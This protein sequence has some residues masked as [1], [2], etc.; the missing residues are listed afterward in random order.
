M[1]YASKGHIC[2]GAVKDDDIVASVGDGITV[3]D[4][5]FRIIYQ[6]RIMKDMFGDCVGQLCHDAYQQAD[7]VCPGCPVAACLSTGDI[8]TVER[9][10][11]VDSQTFTFEI[12]A[13]PVRNHAGETV[14]VVEVVR[15]A[16]RRKVEEE[17]L[18]RMKSLYEALSHTNKA[19]MHIPDREMLFDE[20]CRIAVEYGKLSLAL[21]GTVDPES[22]MIAPAA[23]SGKASEYPGTLRL[24]IDPDRED[25][26]GPTGIAIR[27]GKPY[28]CNDFHNDPATVPWR[29]E[30]L[31]NG[32][33]SSAA[34]PF[35]QDGVCVGALKV[36]A[37]RKDF[38]DD[39]AV[40]LFQEM[41]DNISFALENFLHEERRKRAETLLRASEERLKLVLEGSNDGL[42]DW[43]IESGTITLSERLIEMI[44]FPLEN[45]STTSSDL[46]KLVH[47]DDLE[48]VRAVVYDQVSTAAA[49][50]DIELR[51]ITRNRQHEWVI[52][53]G[54][55]VARD[56]SGKPARVAGVVS[57][58]TGKKLQEEKLQYISLHDPLTG[59]FNRSYF[60][61]EMARMEQSRQY[62]VSIVFADI[63]GLKS[64]N[65]TFGHQ[66][67]DRLIIQAACAFQQ[68][69]RGD[70]IISRIGGDEFAVIL[71]GADAE[72]ARKAI[73]RI[74]ACQTV[75]N[76]GNRGYCLSISLGC[77]TAEGSGQ[78]QD[79]LKRADEE[80]YRDK[81]QKRAQ[82]YSI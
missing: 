35:R 68:S 41:A 27:T 18:A 9:I 4:L 30:A 23:F 48:R 36:Y 15:N 70:D 43:D 53:K 81:Q 66:E 80:M 73:Q 59:L 14:A 22:G 52:C 37:E 69:F 75:I 26:C 5:D 31:A 56:N 51:I 40:H 60:D 2:V 63:D 20:V 72:A 55:V 44:G 24:S 47:P 38:F 29:I 13:S 12:C 45:S 49:A 61:I 6:N 54:K 76:K 25:G 74:H 79:A 34:F 50:F 28:V 32:I 71:H 39:E 57:N 78:L 42:L 3:H 8:Y 64:V 1:S 33:N 46:L 16:T 58:I 17:R 65:D 21:I 62:P 82:A 19:I 67:G 77:A 7:E 10:V 11:T